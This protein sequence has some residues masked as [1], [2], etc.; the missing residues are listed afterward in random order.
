[1]T[2]RQFI[3]KRDVLVTIGLMGLACILVLFLSAGLVMADQKSITITYVTLG[4][5]Q[6][7][8]MP[9]MV[10]AFEAKN[11]GIKVKVEDW[12]FEDSYPK[13]M[14]LIAAGSPPSCGYGLS[15]WVGEFHAR[16]VLAPVEDYLSKDFVNDFYKPL[17]ELCTINGKMVAMPFWASVRMLIYRTDWLKEAGFTAT[18]MDTTEGLLQ[19]VKK[20]YNPDKR[21]YGLSFAGSRYKNTVENFLEFF[22]PFGGEIVSKEGRSVALNNEDGVNALR[23]YAK[24]L[25]YVPPGFTSH[26]IHDVWENIKAGIAFGSIDQGFYTKL[27]EEKE[28]PYKVILPPKNKKRVTLGVL[29]VCLLFDTPYKKEAAKWMEHLQNRE[30]VMNFNKFA[31]F[32]PTRKS[33]EDDPFYKTPVMQ[34]YLKG[35]PYIRFR[36]T[37]P[38]WP[39]IEDALALAVQKVFL[40]QAT[41]KQ[42]LD[43]VATRVNPLFK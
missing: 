39:Q 26:N 30:Y 21:R 17:R 43:E 7:D 25:K 42:A 3:K 31:R 6:M 36:P 4:G 40:N 15:E 24:L 41:P 27:L 13:Y 11:P 22:W 19:V 14:T 29:D 20:V 10:A 9:D 1:M 12:P 8:V 35:I 38:Q 2:T 33:L 5:N 28:I 16:R 23:Y 18:D 37:I 32:I 34:A